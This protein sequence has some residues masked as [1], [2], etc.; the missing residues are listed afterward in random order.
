MSAIVSAIVGLV[1]LLAGRQLYWLFVGAAG[2]FLAFTLTERFLDLQSDVLLL[3][4]AL[5]AGIAGAILAVVAQ[6]LAVAFAGFIAGAL[7]L[8]YVA[9]LMGMQ[10]E[11]LEFIL[12]VVG[13]IIG[14][15]LISLLFDPAH[16]VLHTQ[17]F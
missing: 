16:L 4:I 1:S 7:L 10:G 13:R 14:A 17:H 8:A 11:A 15:I 2:F 9:Q 5:V 3:I 6:R 12:F